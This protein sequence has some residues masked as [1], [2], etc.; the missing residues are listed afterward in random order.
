VVKEAPSLFFLF[1]S[2]LKIGITSFGGYTALVAVLQQEFVHKKQLIPETLV[3]DSLSVA[4]ILPGPLAVNIVAFIGFRLRG[5]P[6]AFIS[7]VAVLLPSVFLMIL[8]AELYISFQYIVQVESFIKGVIPVIIALILSV[9]Y[10]MS[11]KNIVHTWQ[12]V[13]FVCMLVV[14]FFVKGHMFIM[15]M[16][17]IG[18][19]AG[20]FLGDRN[21]IQFRES[22]ERSIGYIM[23]GLFVVCCFYLVVYFFFSHTIQL[24]AFTT[25]SQVSLTLFGGGYVMI[26]ILHDL[27]VDRLAWL[28]SDEFTRAI[29]FGQITPGPILVSATYIGYKIGGLSGAI[30]STVGIFVPAALVM[31]G[32]G[33]AFDKLKQYDFVPAIIAG[34]RPVVIALIS[35]SAYVLFT[36]AGQTWLMAFSVIGAFLVVTFTQ[37]NYLFLILLMGIAGILIFG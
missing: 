36:S 7:L 13:V 35:Y 23:A 17:A 8:L 9:S 29:A 12:K 19:V 28:T 18:G 26:P 3:L 31:V 24:E 2:F 33:N 34:I 32:V 15:G 22:H 16:M 20:Y 37:I 1:R 4:S 6:G 21:P 10:H 5:W 11:Q 14:S 25:F 30:L 27:I